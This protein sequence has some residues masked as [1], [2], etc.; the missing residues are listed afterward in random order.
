MAEQL[1]ESCD[2][3][4]SCFITRMLSLDA[5]EAGRWGRCRWPECGTRLRGEFKF[6]PVIRGVK[7]RPTGYSY[8]NQ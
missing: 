5:R 7:L 6:G 1:E 8:A 3:R 2:T 4:S